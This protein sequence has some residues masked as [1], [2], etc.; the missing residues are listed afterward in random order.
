MSEHNIIL[1]YD[2]YIKK[3]FIVSLLTICNNYLMLRPMTA[4]WLLDI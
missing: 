1:G 3:P 2:N 4:F